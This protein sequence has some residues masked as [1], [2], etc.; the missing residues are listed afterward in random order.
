M[1]E[2][3]DKGI[4]ALSERAEPEKREAVRFATKGDAMVDPIPRLQR[5]KFGVRRNP[6]F[7][8]SSLVDDDLVAPPSSDSDE[9]SHPSPNG[10]QPLTIATRYLLSN[11]PFLKF[12]VRTSTSTESSTSTLQIA[13]FVHPSRSLTARTKN[14]GFDSPASGG[15]E[16]ETNSIRCSGNPGIRKTWRVGREWRGLIWVRCG[17]AGRPGS[18][19]RIESSWIQIS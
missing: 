19:R 2:S 16:E 9:S 8:G 15:R 6:K 7:F 4:K 3:G 18:M 12:I 5:E 14:R 1:V 10:D 13:S 11:F 17:S